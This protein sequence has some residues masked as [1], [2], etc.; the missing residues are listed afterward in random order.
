[1]LEMLAVAA[2]SCDLEFAAFGAIRAQISFQ[3]FRDGASDL[4]SARF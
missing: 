3:V 1:M 4:L 2:L